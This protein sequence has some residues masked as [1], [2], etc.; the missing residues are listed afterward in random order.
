[1]LG[2]GG[3]ASDG[4]N[5]IYGGTPAAADI[6]EF[7]N[8]STSAAAVN[9]PVMPVQAGMEATVV[10]EMSTTVLAKEASLVNPAS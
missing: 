8:I 4:G 2:D 10:T 7:V 3:P 6:L 1:M 9:V 5:V